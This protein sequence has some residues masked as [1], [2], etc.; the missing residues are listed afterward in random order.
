M[1]FKRIALA[2]TLAFACAGAGDL[3]SP[4][5]LTPIDG[6]PDGTE[7]G[8]LAAPLY[9]PP[10]YG[11]YTGGGRC[12]ATYATGKS[13][14]VPQDKK[15]RYKFFASTCVDYV[16]TRMVEA[17]QVFFDTANSRG[18][19]M[20][21]PDSQDRYDVGIKCTNDPFDPATDPPLLGEF[22][23]CTSGCGTSCS[24]VAGLGRLCKVTSGT[25]WIHQGA[26]AHE[27]GTYW[28]TESA[29]LAG[30]RN[31]ILHELGHSVFFAHHGT[32]GVDLM[33]NGGS[34]SSGSAGI[35]YDTYSNAELNML[36]NFAP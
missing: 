15:V 18:W 6:A 11:V 4:D 19:T 22:E 21:G 25:V 12:P 9:M 14:W 3:S 7:L 27:D 34:G 23:Y 16:K 26:T 10:G 33:A 24:T 28:T 32:Q 2:S 13:C 29:S 36:V 8:T 35:G 5:D 17:L 20:Q 1:I 31:V 30:W